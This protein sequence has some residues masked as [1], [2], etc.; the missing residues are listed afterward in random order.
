MVD[1]KRAD[2]STIKESASKYAFAKVWTIRNS[3]TTWAHEYAKKEQKAF[4][5]FVKVLVELNLT[6]KQIEY[7][8]IYANDYAMNFYKSLK[9]SDSNAELAK[10][11]EIALM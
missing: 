7:C 1:L 4:D 2:L 9:I 6:A 8:L 3:V 10:Q 11:L 5:E